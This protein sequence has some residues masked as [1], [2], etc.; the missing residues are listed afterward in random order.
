M[1][2]YLPAADGGDTWSLFYLVP[3]LHLPQARDVGITVE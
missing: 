1:T 2:R 3:Y